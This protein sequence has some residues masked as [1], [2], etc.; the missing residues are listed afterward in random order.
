VVVSIDFETRSPVDLWAEGAYR[1]AQHP[2]TGIYTLS[3]AFGEEDPQTWLPGQ[4]LPERLVLHVEQGGTLLAWN[5]QFERLIWWYV[6][7]PDHGFPEPALE[8]FQCTAARARAHGMPGALGDAARAMGL[9]DG[10]D[11]EGKRLIKTYSANNVPWD[12]IPEQDRASWVEYCERDVVTERAIGQ[13]LRELDWQEWHEYWACERLNDRG[14]PVDLAMAAAALEY[15]TEVRDDVDRKIR[16]LTGGAVRSSNSRTERDAWLLPQLTE[17][18]LRL[19]E[20]YKNGVKKISFDQSHRDALALHPDLSEPVARWLELMGEA[21]GATISK[22]KGMALR[23]IDGRVNGAILWNG[24]GQTGRFASRGLQLHNLRRDSFDEPGPY[25]ADLLAG[26]ELPDVTDTLARLVRSAIHDPNGMTWCDWSAIEGRVAPWLANSI[27]GEAKLDLFREGKD[28]YV[29]TAAATFGIP[30]REVTKDQ[31]QVGKVQELSLQF[32]GGV[33]ALKAMGRNYGLHIEDAWGETLRDRWRA[34]NPWAKAMGRDMER[35][36]FRAIRRPGDWF[37]AGRVAYAYDG[38]DWLWCKLP[39]GRLLAYFQPRIE[40]VDT[41]WGEQ[42]EAVTCVWGAAKAKAGQDWPRR[43]MHAGLWI[44]NCTQAVAA[45]LLREALLSCEEDGVEVFL[46]VHD[47]I[48][49]EGYC[50]EQ[51]RDIML[52]V[53]DWATGLPLAAEGGTG[54]RYGK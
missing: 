18:Q 24:A 15:A 45:D 51:L 1:Y 52:E 27:D 36:T 31:R 3:Y 53:P 44:E 23:E 4:P 43:A 25:I 22:Y 41:P 34:A 13:C 21:G 6:L 11:P 20:T 26:Y 5:A 32:L 8:Q 2:D 42:H 7:T 19:L 50:L 10:K 47:E 12:Q 39:S 46:H 48:V 54:T 33:G 40:L 17:P 16:D 30:E 14:V 28:V 49:A 35:A 37:D 29:A 38:G 9:A